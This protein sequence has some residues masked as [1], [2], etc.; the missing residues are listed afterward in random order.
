M[1]NLLQTFC[2]IYIRHYVEFIKL[3]SAYISEASKTAAFGS[4]EEYGH[5]ADTYSPHV[6]SWMA[7]LPGPGAEFAHAKGWENPVDLVRQYRDLEA[8][9][10]PDQ[11]RMP[12]GDARRDRHLTGRKRERL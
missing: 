8:M 10:G 4:G 11:A 12:G 3:R 2:L 5:S 9:V 1:N 7:D 6:I